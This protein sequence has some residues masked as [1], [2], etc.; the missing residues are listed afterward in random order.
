MKMARNGHF[1]TITQ[2][3][4]ECLI[5]L[6]YNRQENKDEMFQKLLLFMTAIDHYLQ[7]CEV[8][9]LQKFLGKINVQIIVA[10]F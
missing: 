10:R 8:V 7:P 5:K 1:R 9:S 6:F 3:N 2:D 4:N